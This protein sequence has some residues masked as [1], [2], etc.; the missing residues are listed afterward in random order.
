MNPLQELAHSLFVKPPSDLFSW[1]VLARRSLWDWYGLGPEHVEGV[2]SEPDAFAQLAVLSAHP[3]GRVREWAVLALAEHGSRALP[4][5][6]LR[7]VDWV[8]PVRMVARRAVLAL[9]V[10]AELDAFIEAL[11]L[12]LRTRDFGRAG[13]PMMNE[14]AAFLARQ[15]DAIWTRVLTHQDVG[16]RRAGM[17]LLAERGRVTT[18]LLHIALH[19][20]DLTVRARAARLVTTAPE[21]ESLRAMLL[22]DRDPSLSLHAL[23]LAVSVDPAPHRARLER[24][25]TDRVRAMRELARHH[26]RGGQFPDRETSKQ[27][28][29]GFAP[30]YRAKLLQPAP[31]IAAIQGLAETGTSGDWERL[32]PALDVSPKHACAALKAMATLDRKES[33]ETRLMMVDDPR[34]RVSQVA[35]NTMT[36]DLWEAD[37]SILRAYLT[38]PHR[39][40]Q[41]RAIQLATL[42]SGWTAPLLFSEVEDPTLFS[43]VRVHLA[44]W[45]QRRRVSI[46]APTRDECARLE[47]WAERVEGLSSLSEYLHIFAKR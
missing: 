8:V 37:A 46:A 45:L 27:Y 39:H 10:D 14:I 2:N 40:V 32:L 7:C 6:L 33:R 30:F 16:V 43:A 11:P 31:S 36:R 17:T 9:L 41:L 19:D 12:A 29:D 21:M 13:T 26:L 38:S 3:N 1:D 42:L 34:A 35:A 23:R 28:P 4:W 15:S 18:A 5:L 20:R 24:A 44:R 22:N 25:L 47:A